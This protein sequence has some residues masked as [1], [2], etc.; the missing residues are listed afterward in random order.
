MKGKTL[1]L[2][3]WTMVAFCTVADGYAQ[4]NLQSGA[5]VT[6][7]AVTRRQDSVTVSMT[8]DLSAVKVKSGG[9]ILLHPRYLQSGGTGSA[10]LPPVEV[11]GRTRSLYLRRNPEAAY[12]DEVY[13]SVVCRRGE[14]QSVAYRVTLPYAGWMDHSRLQIVEDLCGCGRVTPGACADLVEEDLSF[15]PRLAY[16]VPQAEPVKTREL[17]GRAYLDFRLNRTDIDPAYRRNPDEL[18][19][20]LAS[21]DTVKN[22]R[23]FTITSIELCGYASPEGSYAS[24]VRLAQGRTEALKNYLTDRY[25][26][27]PSLLKCAYE[28]ENWQG[29]ADYLEAS[30]L[31]DR[32]AILDYLANGPAD[33]DVKERQLRVRFPESYKVLLE[34]CYPGLRRTDYRINY[35]IRSFNLEEARRLVC[36]APGRLSLEEMFAVAQTYEP[37]SADFNEVFDV[38]VRMYPDSDVANLNAANALLE[39]GRAEEALAYLDRVKS[40]C[41]EAEN[42][43]GVACILLKDYDKARHHMAVAREAGLP[44]AEH[45]MEFLE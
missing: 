43:R 27:P 23:D 20:I 2:S 9:S 12:A 10:W 22:D 42:A 44:A 28:P 26:F 29:L 33:V 19:R 21:V 4:Q 7:A 3:I 25:G 18:K 31:P 11:M 38:A 45:N 13:C 16:V 24:N 6:D 14:Q 15:E 37:G 1:L 41:P 40:A 39:Q 36:T 34:D 5:V 32:E 8:L 17:D 30:D 35:V